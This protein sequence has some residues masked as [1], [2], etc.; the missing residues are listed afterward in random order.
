MYEYGKSI[1]SITIRRFKKGDKL[2]SNLLQGS[3][4]INIEDLEN[5]ISKTKDLINKAKS[6]DI[7][8]P[9]IKKK[10]TQE[11]QTSF[12]QV[13]KLKKKKDLPKVKTDSIK[14]KMNSFLESFLEMVQ[15]EDIQRIS[16]LEPKDVSKIVFDQNQTVD[17]VSYTHL[18]LPTILL[19]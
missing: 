1:G 8:D 11:I 5:I 10:L 17:A 15:T 7:K 6:H 9:E 4:I 14:L 16:K 13:D 12:I 2:M 3:K 18:T 19:V